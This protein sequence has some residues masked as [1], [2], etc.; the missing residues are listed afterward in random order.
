MY[1]DLCH[2]VSSLWWLSIMWARAA[3]SRVFLV[4][5]LTTL[6]VSRLYSVGFIG[7]GSQWNVNWK[8]KPKYSEKIRH[9]ATLSTRHSTWPDM[10]SIPGRRS[11]KPETN[12]LL[13]DTPVTTCCL[14]HVYWCFGNGRTWRN[15]GEHYQVTRRHFSEDFT[16][17][18]R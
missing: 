16:F 5:H 7:G 11:G 2:F 1:W 6:S 3:R 12:R 17:S 15:V 10:G 8:G 18:R 4:G 13:C 14:V 9:N